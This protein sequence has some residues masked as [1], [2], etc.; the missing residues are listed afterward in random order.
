[1]VKSYK[2][3]KNKKLQ[4]KVAIFVMKK[5]IKLNKKL[6]LL[7][8]QIPLAGHQNSRTTPTNHALIGLTLCYLLSSA[9]SALERTVKVHFHTAQF[10]SVFFLCSTRYS[11][12]HPHRLLPITLGQSH[13]LSQWSSLFELSDWL[14]S[15]CVPVSP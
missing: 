14:Q 15:V 7:S 2:K 12:S 4:Y 13:S 10:H 9:Y 3:R 6:W 8:H 5:E 11:L 1:M